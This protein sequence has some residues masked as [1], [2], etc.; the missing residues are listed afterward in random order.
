MCD[1]RWSISVFCN[2]LHLQSKATKGT[3][4]LRN[5]GKYSRFSYKKNAVFSDTAVRNSNLS[6]AMFSDDTRAF[7]AVG[8]NQ[9]RVLRELSAAP[10]LKAKL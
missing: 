10:K 2:A 6:L 3:T 5:V 8:L 9:L 1:D 7:E 4:I